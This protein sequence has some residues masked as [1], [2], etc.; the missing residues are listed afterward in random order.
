MKCP[1][2]LEGPFCYYFVYSHYSSS[3]RNCSLDPP[4]PSKASLSQVGVRPWPSLTIQDHPLECLRPSSAGPRFL[5]NN[6]WPRTMRWQPCSSHSGSWL[7]YARRSWNMGGTAAL[8]YS[9]GLLP[10]GLALARFPPCTECYNRA[11]VGTSAQ[12]Y[13]VSCTHQQVGCYMG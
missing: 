1:T 2:L 11:I 5:G 9:Y 10:F 13:F 4:Q 3:S 6:R 12:P 8:L 7:V